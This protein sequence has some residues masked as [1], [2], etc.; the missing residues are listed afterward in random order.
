MPDSANAK[1]S[2]HW[3]ERDYSV[4]DQ[5]FIASSKKKIDIL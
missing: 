3:D 5:S 1:F 4:V 2:T